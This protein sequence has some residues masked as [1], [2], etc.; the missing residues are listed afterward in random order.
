MKH[1][2][3]LLTALLFIAVARAADLPP[4]IEDLYLTDAPTDAIT[5]EDG[6][7]AIYVRPALMPRVLLRCCRASASNRC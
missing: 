6:R 2:V 3:T 4:Q 1:T 7:S 5:L